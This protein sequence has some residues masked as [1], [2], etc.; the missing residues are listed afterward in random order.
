MQLVEASQVVIAAMLVREDRCLPR[1]VIPDG[2][3]GC[4][5]VFVSDDP[6]K[7]LASQSALADRK[8]AQALHVLV[9]PEAAVDAILGIVFRTDVAASVLAVN[10]DLAIEYHLLAAPRDGLAQLHEEHPSRLVLNADFTRELERR[11][12]L[13]R[14]RRESDG[15][16]H[17]LEAQLPRRKD[18]ARG[19]AEHGLAGL[20][21]AFEAV[22]AHRVAPQRS[23]LW[24]VRLALR[25]MPAQ[26]L[27]PIVG[28]RIPHPGEGE[29][30]QRSAL[31][32]EQEVL[33]LGCVSGFR[34]GST[35]P[36][37]GGGSGVF[38][39]PRPRH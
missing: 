5:A 13:H 25:L 26:A 4:V 27:K 7:R 20:V 28:S 8:S 22:A 19:D 17:L 3:P 11:L 2:R 1:Q 39:S 18:R 29:H 16:E 15:D 14:V 31:W 32:R 6:G 24:A 35:P 23:A 10:L 38:S 37:S 36:R 30:R 34:H 12:P 9:F 33:A 21:G